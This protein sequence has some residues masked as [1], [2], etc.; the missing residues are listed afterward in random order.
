M[1]TAQ[2]QSSVASTS[3]TVSTSQ[4]TTTSLHQRNPRYI[5]HSGDSFDVTF[6]FSPEFNQSLIVQPDGYVSLR[7]IGDIHVSGLTLDQIQQLLVLK[8]S[9]ILKQPVISV[10]PKDLDKTYFIATGE[11]YKPGKYEIRGDVTVT[12][13]I[14]MAGG[15]TQDRAKHSE[16]VLFHRQGD[17]LGPGTVI[18]LKKMLKDRN[19]SEDVLIRPGDLV[20]VPQNA[21]S[22]I[23]QILPTP[24]V[25]MQV[26]PGS[27]F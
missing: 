15:F 26:I 17:A 5:L 7:E 9:A 23:R 19:L 6:E 3:P 18:D 10:T 4:D 20:Y 22:K 27:T 16:I 11:V 1:S 13:A 25:G 12:Q 8:Y 14:A 2:E 24:G 21:W